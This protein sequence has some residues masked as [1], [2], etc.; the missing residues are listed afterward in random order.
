[1][2]NNKSSA[3]D[4]LGEILK[5]HDAESALLKDVREWTRKWI[6]NYNVTEQ[7]TK[8]EN[9]DPD[10]FLEKHERIGKIVFVKC[11]ER[12]AEDCGELHTAVMEESGKIYKSYNLA[13]LRKEP[14]E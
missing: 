3:I 6:T 2:I 11:A 9:N 4:A 14:I 12:A 1:M 10:E 8:S 13:A 5:K 7:F